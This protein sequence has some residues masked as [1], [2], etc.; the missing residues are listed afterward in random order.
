MLKNKNNLIVGVIGL[1]VGAFHLKNSLS[2]KDIRVKYICD[3]NHKKLFYYKKK[4]N[5]ENA[6][7]FFED[8]VKDKEVDAIIIAS[9]DKYHAYQV[10]NSLK[11]NKHVFIEKPM[12]LTLKELDMIIKLKKDK[13]KL[14]LSSNLVLRTHPFFKNI[15]K[16]KK[17][18]KKIYYLEGDYNYGRIDKLTKGWRGKVKN[19]SV[20][21]G[22]GIHLL[23]LILKLKG[24]K[25][26]EIF[27][28]GNKIISNKF[29]KTPD[30]FAVSFLKFED[31]SIAKI[32]SNYSSSSDHHHIF[33]IYSQNSSFFYSRNK[34]EQYFKEKDRRPKKEK[35]YNHNNKAKGQMLINFFDAIRKKKQL[36]ISQKDLFYLMKICL[37]M[38]QSKIKNKIIK[39]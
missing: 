17:K 20:I 34:S 6:T 19:Y 36:I 33:N 16:E 24:K 5:I 3:I 28:M 38:V 29:K 12:C 13:P 9:N 8:V 23:D 11:N 37:L 27:T 15:I 25:V 35:K 2:Y 14:C 4:F 31:K 22:G 10:S 18:I 1:G 39:L 26:K 7:K 21:L 30:D 32:S